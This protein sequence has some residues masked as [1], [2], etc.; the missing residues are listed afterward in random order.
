VTARA[1]LA[2]MG[3]PP[4]EALRF[5]L[6][7]V[8][9]PTRRWDDIWGEQHSHAFMVAGAMSQALLND[10]R[11]EIQA[12]MEKGT[13]LGEFRQRFEEIVRKHGW[14]HTGTPGWRAQIIYET[15]LSSAYSAG[16]WAQMTE[17]DTLAVFP[18]W[19]YVHSGAEHPRLQH[20]AWNGL[21]LRAD[22]PW[23]RTHY[24]PNG[25]RCGCRVR[26]LSARDLARQGKL[27]PDR[28]PP[29]RLRPY[30]RSDGRTVMIPEGID[31]GFGHNPGE[32]QRGYQN[33]IPSDAVLRPPPGW[34][35]PAPALPAAVPAR[36]DL[37]APLTISSAA[38]AERS[39][40]APYTP[41]GR[42]LSQGEEAA[43]GDYKGVMGIVINRFLRAPRQ[44]ALAPVELVRELD[45]A[46]A[47][48]VAPIDLRLFRGIGP[49]EAARLARSAEGA[50]IRRRGF[51]STSAVSALAARFDR[52]GVQVEILVKAGTRGVAYIHP[53]PEYRFPQAEVL[54][55][56]GARFQLIERTARRVV[57]LLLDDTNEAAE[58]E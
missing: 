46:L 42:G 12:A 52:S 27:G 21:T 13:S 54:I 48:A 41:W 35:P 17:P 40:L 45:T 19:Q 38:E 6:Q 39:L 23:W 57:L 16:R 3:L 31:P 56:R 22:D 33:V 26:P 25:W 14:S 4:R 28:A 15:N 9:V 51:L 50:V 43:L 37:P 49:A 29:V 34:P 47:R 30:T 20:L 1:T 24:P 58:L 18:Y 11:T 55:R 32:A 8:N 36:R 2:A 44:A 5:F 7:K 10:F 53:F